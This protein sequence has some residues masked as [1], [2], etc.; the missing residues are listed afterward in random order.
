M[1]FALWRQEL[2]RQRQFSRRVASELD[3]RAGAFRIEEVYDIASGSRVLGVTKRWRFGEVTLPP[4]EVLGL[5]PTHWAAGTLVLI[6]PPD[7]QPPVVAWY[8]YPEVA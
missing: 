5:D 2:K 8:T 7:W 6:V 1:T 3:G 4:R